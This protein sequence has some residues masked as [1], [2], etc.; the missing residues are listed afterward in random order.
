MK[1]FVLAVTPTGSAGSATGANRKGVGQGVLE[2]VQVKYTG[3]PST[4]DIV[5]TSILDGVAHT[6]LTLTNKNT[7]I[8][9]TPVL[10][11]ALDAAGVVIVDDAGP[12]VISGQWWK[13][14]VAGELVITITGAT[15]VER[16]IIV[17]CLVNLN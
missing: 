5:L 14:V 11:L 16:G 12:P 7:N 6:I 8:P 1:N 2:A 3:Q 17:N 10:N 15:N 4:T 9:F 13:P